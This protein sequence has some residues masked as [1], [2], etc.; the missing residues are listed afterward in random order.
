MTE[1]Y[2]RNSRYACAHYWQGYATCVD[3]FWFFGTRQSTMVFTFV[4]C[5]RS[6]SL[7]NEE[8]QK[9]DLVHTKDKFLMH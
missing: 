2:Q 5:V 8:S 4:V 9:W 6:T 7:P 1:P 3:P